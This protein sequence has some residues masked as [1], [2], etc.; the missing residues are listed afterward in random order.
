MRD[1]SV[2]NWAGLVVVILVVGAF[3]VGLTADFATF[4]VGTREIIYAITG[5]TPDGRGFAAYPDF[6]PDD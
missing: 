6:T 1:R 4:S 5:R 2:V 3:Y